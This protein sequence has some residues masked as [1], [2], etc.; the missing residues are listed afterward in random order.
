[1]VLRPDGAVGQTSGVTHSGLHDPV[2]GSTSPSNTRHSANVQVR[3]G[4]NA[5]PFEPFGV[6]GSWIDQGRERNSIGAGV[7]G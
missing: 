2:V 1:M 4:W 6:S 7:R 3:V 5:D